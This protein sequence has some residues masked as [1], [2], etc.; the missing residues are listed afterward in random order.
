MKTKILQTY[1]IAFFLLT[2]FIAFAQ[3]G[4]GGDVA[5]IEDNDPPPTPINGKLVWLGIAA[6]LF[7]FYSIQRK[8]RVA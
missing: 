5:P 8:R 2:D 3:P 7:A 6:L 4:S 1:L